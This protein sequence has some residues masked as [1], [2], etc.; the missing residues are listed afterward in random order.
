MS[1]RLRSRLTA[2]ERRVA[3][4]SP[5]VPLSLEERREQLRRILASLKRRADLLASRP[6]AVTQTVSPR[7]QSLIAQLIEKSERMRGQSSTGV[8]AT[9]CPG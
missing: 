9:T 7:V 5:R 2:I 4:E 6:G 1:N 3:R 8:E